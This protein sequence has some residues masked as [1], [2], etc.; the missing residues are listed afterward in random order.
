MS[1][2]QFCSIVV[3]DLIN[4]VF[5]IGLDIVSLPSQGR[6]GSDY[7]IGVLRNSVMLLRALKG[8]LFDEEG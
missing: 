7:R 2:L 4:E 6:L 5:V 8:K 3:R 1:H